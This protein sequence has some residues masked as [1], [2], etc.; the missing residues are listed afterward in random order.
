MRLHATQL[1]LVIFI[2]VL[3]ISAVSALEYEKKPDIVVSSVYVV[4]EKVMQPISTNHLERGDKKILTIVVYNDARRESV[5]YDSEQESMFF[6]GREDM[7]FTAYNVRFELIGDGSI[8]V[9]TPVQEIPALRPFEPLNLQ[10]VVKVKESA[11]AGE[12]ELKL[13]V[14]YYRLE[15]LAKIQ[16]FLSDRSPYFQLPETF[17][18]SYSYSTTDPQNRTI[19]NTT[20]YEYRQILKEYELDYFEVTK[21]VPIIVYVEERD[22]KLKV[23]DVLADGLRG[24]SKGSVEVA[25]ENAGG[26]TAHNAYLVL[27]LP[28]GFE[29]GAG[30]AEETGMP[31]MPA[32]QMPFGAA[33]PTMPAM[34]APTGGKGELSYY[35]GDLSPGEIAKARFYLKINVKEAGNYTFHVKLKYLDDYGVLRES[36]EV[37]FGVY[38][39]PAPKFD[40]K[41]VESRVYVNAKG[42]LRVTMVFDTDLKDVSVVL[43]AESPLSVLSSEYY[44]G[45][46]ESGKEVTAI[47]KL[48]ASSEAKP[49]TYPAELRVK[50]LA[51]DEYIESDPIRIGV[52]VNP[53]M[54]FEVSGVP[55]IS[56]G[57][58]K[59]ISFTI[60]NTGNF[61]IRDAMARITI[62][63]PFSSTDDSAYIGTLKPGEVAEAKFKVSVDKDAT[64]KLYALNLEVKYKDPEGEWAISEPAKAVVEVMPAKP[65]YMLY[66]LVALVIV[67][68][69]LAYIKRR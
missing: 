46:V 20:T 12:H 56:A 36:D 50:Y 57:E 43:S 5:K 23:V 61:E 38:V 33:V 14:T 16:P 3:A 54:S 2:S 49:V 21:E 40:V 48:K 55:K 39:A 60:K 45:D 59:I 64:P 42:E 62:V 25:V 34:P 35:V 58:E 65:P 19:T 69:L 31:G 26:K 1:I 44:V 28:N 66:A 10:F 24:K 52:K 15:D 7:I 8:E 30:E 47:F 63:D 4:D 29:G 51:I 13:K 27:S 53:K 67:A 41:D 22:V 18:T 68:A 37:P 17:S 6:S 9:K 11:A 32:A